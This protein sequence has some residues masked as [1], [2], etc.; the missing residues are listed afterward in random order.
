[1]HKLATPESMLEGGE[2]VAKLAS[3]VPDVIVRRLARDPALLV[4]PL[5]EKFTGAVLIADVSG[6]TAIT[7]SLAKRGSLGAETL[8]GMMNDYFGRAIAV[9]ADARRRR[10][11]LRRRRL[12]GGLVCRARRETSPR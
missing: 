9:I 5:A 3:Y 2:L 10:G 11:A 6:F 1:M 4:E 12:A 8:S 7:E